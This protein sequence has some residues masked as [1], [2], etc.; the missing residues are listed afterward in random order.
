MLNVGNAGNTIENPLRRMRHEGAMQEPHAT[1]FGAV[2]A[3]RHGPS[4]N[5]RGAK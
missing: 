1:R 3:G 4:T 5:D 2:E